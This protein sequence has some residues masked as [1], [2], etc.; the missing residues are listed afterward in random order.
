MKNENISSII[1]WLT[2][3][4]IVLN[5]NNVN[6]L[7]DLPQLQTQ[8]SQIESKPRVITRENFDETLHEPLYGTFVMFQ[9]P[10]CGHCKRM[11]LT[12][13]ELAQRHNYQKKFLIG[14][15]DCTTET[16]FCSE[17][18][19][20]GYPTFIFYKKNDLTGLRY[21]G[22]RDIETMELFMFNQINSDNAVDEKIESFEMVHQLNS[23]DF[24]RFI[25]RGFHF[26]KFFAP[27]CGHCQK[28]AS[29]WKDL[30]LIYSNKEVKIS[31]VDCTQHASVCQ[32][33][34]INGYPTLIFFHDG[35]K[36]QNYNGQRTIE[37]FSSFIDSLI[38]LQQSPVQNNGQV[39][40]LN[41]KNYLNVLEQSELLFVKYFA[42]WCGHCRNMAPTWIELA[43]K[44]SVKIL[45]AEVD[46][47]VYD[48]ICTKNSINGYP[49]LIMYK[50]GKKLEEYSGARDLESLTTFINK[51]LAHDEL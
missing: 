30:A 39:M 43:S 7:D 22:L 18:D 3:F 40:E 13:I 14:K 41:D 11:L 47:T 44:F 21:D 45:I 26:V 23:A 19:I 15:V 32:S 34:D 29:T 27:W 10:W 20:L 6:S 46:C 16:E 28:M 48:N 24:E 2:V 38:V 4:Y 25:S 9:A 12:W 8:D 36:I 50:K 51:Y 5:T 35:K 37:E 42:P 49:T 1:L 33:Y 31:E 17:Y